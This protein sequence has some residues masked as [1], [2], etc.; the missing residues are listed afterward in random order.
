[1]VVDPN[2]LREPGFSWLSALSLASASKLT[3][4]SEAT[5][6]A[7]VS[8]TWG[9]ELTAF[10]HV[11]KTDTQAFIAENDGAMVVAFRGT[12]SPADWLTNI[13]I[14]S[15]ERPYGAVHRGFHEAFESAAGPVRENVLRASGQQKT[16]WLTGHSLGGALASLAA[17]DLQAQASLG[18]VMTFGQ[19]RL[20]DADARRAVNELISPVY[21]RFVNDDDIVTRIPPN[22]GHAGSLIYFDH[23]GEVISSS[24]ES[25]DDDVGPEPPA[26]SPDEFEDIQSEIGTIQEAPPNDFG[27]E[28]EGGSTDDGFD[29]S[30]EGLIPGL[31]DHRIANYIALIQRLATPP[32]FHS[33]EESPAR[34]DA[35]VATNFAIGL[36]TAHSP[37]DGEF[38]ELRLSV[39]DV[40]RYPVLLRLKYSSWIPPENLN[41]NSR[42]A[43]FATA[44]VTTDQLNQLRKD[45][46]VAS[47]ELSREAG[48]EELDNSIPFTKGDLVH[49]PDIAE[50][51]DSALVGIIDTGI[52]VL[53]RAFLNADSTTRI[54]AIWD[55]SNSQGPSP[56]ALAPGHF[57]QDYGTVYTQ[58]DIDAMLA[59]YAA[60]GTQPASALRDPRGHGTHVASIAAGRAVGAMSNGMAP[61]ALIAG[62]IPNMR[63]TEP[64][65]PTSLGYSLSHVDALVFLKTLAET[66]NQILASSQPVAI[67]VSLGMNAGPHDGTTTLEAAFDTITGKGRDAGC[68]IV[69]SAGN[70]RTHAGHARCK[71]PIGVE[72]IEWISKSVSRQSDYFEA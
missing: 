11:D 61:D 44:I 40:R 46:G 14:V 5:I 45:S 42:F 2:A 15:T 9:M 12:H 65:S 1:M 64:G 7:Q 21:F 52:D 55:Q 48:I 13:E 36:V 50:C 41:L 67:N 24:V 47:I 30:A 28:T 27:V 16:V 38:S 63:R 33:S 54:V 17:M 39:E 3:Y 37:G 69:K 4:E 51:G 34:E 53:H 18:G 59:D 19:P 43:T 35:G 26:L 58:A 60:A 62:V 66:D 49:R 32:E 71:A 56:K 72:T 68:V 70:E 29:T 6:Q 31:N 10:I 8:K 22:F 20:F 57:T 23:N 25:G